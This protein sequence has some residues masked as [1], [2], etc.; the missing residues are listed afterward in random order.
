MRRTDIL[1]KAARAV[2]RNKAN[3]DL[4]VSVPDDDIL[5]Y[6]NDAQDRMQNL[7]SATKNISKI[8]VTQQ[9]ISVVANQENYEIPDRVLLNKQIENVEYSYDG[10]LGNY[11][12]L[13]KVNFINRDTNTS[14]YPSGY[15][16]RGGEI[17]LV[18]IPA[19]T[20]GS[21]RVTYERTLDDLD[22]PRGVLSAVTNGTSAQFDTFTLDT[23]ADAY[24]S[25]TPGWSNIQYASIV[26]PFGARKC[27]NIL[28]GTYNT[29]TNVVTPSPSPF[30]YSSNDV[31]ITIGDVAVFGK[32]TTTFSGLPD[33]CERYLIHYAAAEL[34]RGDSSTDYAAAAAKVDDIEEDTLKAL[35]SQ[36]SEVQEIPEHNTYDW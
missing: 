19:V 2:G 35:S 5:Q 20:Q 26:D 3:A 25:T 14:N 32:Y 21:L 12:R 27:F 15:Y 13:R 31:Q 30:I 34:F 4:T 1:I 18:P 9:I 6:L 36:T 23:T 11:V 8:F 28:L 17:F 16:K 24:E 10:A 22:I 7:I 33:D 29:G